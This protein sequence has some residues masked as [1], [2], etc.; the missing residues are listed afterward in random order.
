[1][2]LLSSKYRYLRFS[3]ACFLIGFVAASIQLTIT[4]IVT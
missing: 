1:V 3:Y 2:Y 4:M